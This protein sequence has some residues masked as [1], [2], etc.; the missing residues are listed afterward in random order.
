MLHTIGLL[1]QPAN[2]WEKVRDVDVSAAKVFLSHT[3]LFALIAPVSAY[4]GTT[5]TGWTVGQGPVVKL[6]SASAASLSIIFYFAVLVTT[7]SVAAMVRW[8]SETY[9]AKVS[10]GGALALA[11]YSA[12]PMFIMG[13]IVLWPVLWMNLLAGL[14]ALA[15]TLYLFYTGVPIMARIPPERG[16]LMASAMLAFGLVALVALLAATALAWGFGFAPEFTS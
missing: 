15:Y 8:M 14:P 6:T 5:T 16:F 2:Q 13:A 1:A 11:S 4:I 12:T 9:G 3:W 7:F 10:F